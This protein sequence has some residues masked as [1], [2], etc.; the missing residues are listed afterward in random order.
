MLKVLD[1]QVVR[2]SRVVDD[3]LEFVHEPAIGKGD[4]IAE[5]PRFFLVAKNAV[6]LIVAL[7]VGAQTIQEQRQAF[8]R[9]AACP[10]PPADARPD[11]E[12]AHELT[13]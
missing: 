6:D 5:K 3:K 10:N 13:H 2:R 7:Q 8:V 12:P 1:K 11:D 4:E 9:Q